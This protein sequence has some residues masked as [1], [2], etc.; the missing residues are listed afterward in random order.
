MA[1]PQVVGRRGPDGAPGDVVTRIPSRGGVRGALR[2]RPDRAAAH[3]A[4]CG[5]AHLRTDT[6]K[7]HPP[8]AGWT[9]WPRHARRSTLSPMTTNASRLLRIASSS[10]RST[11]S[12]TLPPAGARN[13]GRRPL[14][15]GLLPLAVLA[16]AA[17]WQPRLSGARGGALSLV[18]GVFGVEALFYTREV[19]ASGG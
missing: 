19:G 8:E 18:L 9:Q 15:S 10:S 4:R 11:S 13:V 1:A 17:W 5:Q 16:A 12:T 14:L 2:R 7:R 3:T 6:V